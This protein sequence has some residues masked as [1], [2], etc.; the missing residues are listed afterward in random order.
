MEKIWVR[1]AGGGYAVHV[2]R[3]VLEAALPSLLTGL[4]PRRVAVVTHQSIMDLHGGSLENSLRKA[5]VSEGHVAPFVFPEGE[6]HKTLRTLEEGYR[7][8]LRAG[9]NRE[10]LILAFGGGVV[11]DLAGF[12]AATY[13]RGIRYLQVPTTLMAM[14]DSSIGGKVGVDLPE[15]KNLVGAFYR[16]EAVLADMRLLET[17]PRREVLSG[18]AEVAKYGFL[19]DGGILAEMEGWAEGI[20]GA[21][22][23]FSRLVA[24]CAARKA[25][26][27]SADERDLS[28][29]RVLLNYGH[30]F[31]HA[32]EAATAYHVLRHGE[33]VALGMIMAARLAESIGMARVN[34]LNRHLRVL[35]PLLREARLPRDLSAD[36]ILS[37][38]ETDKKKA[39]ALRFVLLEDWQ[40]PRLAEFPSADLVGRAVEETLREALSLREG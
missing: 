21:G 4:S 26:V 25:G 7:A 18:L 6:E 10:D 13:M 29:E 15:G 27:V 32:L 20:P 23:D 30:T 35:S 1:S 8:L 17:L 2:G 33:A 24:A 36:L 40:E 12:L 14:V 37:L 38:M 19:Y 11:G 31:G 22:Y 16:P 39:G 28:G 5:S 9:V 3:G 34:L